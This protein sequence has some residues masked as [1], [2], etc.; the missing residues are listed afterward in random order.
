MINI[1]GRP[2]RRRSGTGECVAKLASGMVSQFLLLTLIACSRGPSVG[3]SSPGAVTNQ[4][5]S[6]PA[7]AKREANLSR[8][9]GRIWRMSDAPFGSASGSIYVFLPNGTLLE[10]SCV[11]TYRIATWSADKSGPGTLQVTED[12][13]P[14]FTAKLGE[15]TDRTLRLQKTL[16]LGNR[17]THDL[18]LTAIDKEFVCPDIRK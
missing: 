16:L 14:A 11:E 13:R 5:P 6:T 2:R 12:D 9:I 1:F 15:A 4:P 7:A 10:T 18:T 3:D 17:E 8:L